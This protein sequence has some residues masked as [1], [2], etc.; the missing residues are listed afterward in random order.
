[1]EFN[2]LLEVAIALAII[3]IAGIIGY[4]TNFT[5]VPYLIIGG[6]LI[7]PNAPV[8][9]SFDFRII[10][11]ESLI[12]FLGRLGV[13][14]LLFYLG[15]EFSVGRLLQAGKT[16]FWSGSLY[17]LVVFSLGVL[18]PYS[19]GWP[20]LE[21]IIAAGIFSIS[22]SAIVAKVLID[23]KRTARPESEIIL[24]LMLFQDIFVA[25]YL[26]L[27]SSLTL[28]GTESINLTIISSLVS[29]LFIV[30][31]VMVGMKAV[32]IW[33][34]I[35][36]ITSD[37]AFM[38]IIFSLLL[39]GS[40]MAESLHIAEAI[41][42]LLVGLILAE[43][44]HAERIR[45]LVVPYRDFFGALFFFSFGMTID[46]FALQG[47]IVQVLI[48]VFAT[49]L[50][51]FLVGMFI[52]RKLGYS[53]FASLNIGLTITARGEF[54]IV[55]ANLA[56]NGGLLAVLQ[57]FAALYVL[58]LSLLGPLI[59]KESRRIYALFARFLKWPALPAPRKKS[60]PK[61]ESTN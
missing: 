5:L 29:L 12:S 20:L 10:A 6:M 38:L 54:S 36:D 11:S 24:G 15:L 40:V 57:P 2:L 59:T 61:Q 14:F 25:I 28:R 51:S 46:M 7:G 45:T 19:W 26:S 60:K 53:H 50:V 17:M 1:M 16:I 31:F 58:L 9:G 52:G 47:A 35:L 3:A 13:L 43:T 39:W 49:I 8:F 23:F 27:A 56:R 21:C 33:N 34:K 4:K 22:S 37:E 55:L 30:V 44:E 42:A 18:L 48:A 32:P 41:G